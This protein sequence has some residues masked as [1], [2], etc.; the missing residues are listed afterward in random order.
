MP[1]TVM[2]TQDDPVAQAERDRLM[3]QA[4]GICGVE[5]DYDGAPLKHFSWCSDKN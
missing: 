5:P 4:C 3:P 1:F 2:D